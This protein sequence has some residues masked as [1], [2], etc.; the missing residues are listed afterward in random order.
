MFS[1]DLGKLLESAPYLRF[2]FLGLFVIVFLIELIF[3]LKGLLKKESRLPR[4]IEL[5][6][7]AEDK[8][9]T[10]IDF[11]NMQVQDEIFRESTGCNRSKT[12]RLI[13][14]FYL[15]NSEEF[16]W[17]DMMLIMARFE[18]VEGDLKLKARN[19]LFRLA[20]LLYYC[21]YGL[22]MLL[23]IFTIVVLIYKKQF[24]V[25]VIPLYITLGLS[26]WMILVKRDKM[27]VYKKV[28]NKLVSKNEQ[29]NIT[30]EVEK[31]VDHSV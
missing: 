1:F 21:Y 11:I 29:R 28:F 9:K 10:L 25:L 30:K 13:I 14:D 31:S 15:S 27:R 18:I 5:L 22:F 3:K 4:L 26:L 12:N 16:R 8:D 19:F 24:L 20:E 17:R 2:F 23:S 6:R 7:I